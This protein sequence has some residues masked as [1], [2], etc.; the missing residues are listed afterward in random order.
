MWADEPAGAAPVEERRSPVSTGVLVLLGLMILAAVIVLYRPALGFQLMGDDYQWWQHAHAAMHRPALLFSDLDTFY[1]PAS[2]WTLVLDRLLL[3][4]SPEG[5]HLSNV[6]FHG[7]AGFLLLLVGRRLGL[8][9]AE[10]AAIGLLWVLSPFSEEPAVSVAIRFQDL[11][12]MAWLGL[13][14]AWP[15]KGRAM[16]PVRVGAIAVIT[17]LAAASKETWVMTA[18]LVP[19]LEAAADRWGLRR[20]LRRA[21]PFALAAAVYT[22]IYFA[23]F[24]GGKGYFSLDPRV[25]FKVPHQLAAFLGMEPQHRGVHRPENGGGEPRRQ[26][27]PASPRCFG[28]VHGGILPGRRAGGGSVGRT[29]V[30][31]FQRL[32]G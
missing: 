6:L 22:A 21:A 24:P 29:A 19:A 16:T 8:P 5:F 9:L 13:I 20:W 30:I 31:P 32:N 2:T 18:A 26:P 14:L 25:L 7:A 27:L 4:D 1:R 15:G 3:G 17:L 10:S 12:L 23:V 28:G 11:L